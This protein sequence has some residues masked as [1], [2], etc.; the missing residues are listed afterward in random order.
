MDGQASGVLGDE[1]RDPG[2]GALESGG[3]TVAP[4]GRDVQKEF[5]STRPLGNREYL[6]GWGPALMSITKARKRR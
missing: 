4:G 3:G 2:D 5:V 1:T 6:F